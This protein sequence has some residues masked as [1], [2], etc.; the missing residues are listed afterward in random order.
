MISKEEF[1]RKVKAEVFP[2]LLATEQERKK[3][4]WIGIP[5]IVVALFLL[6]YVFIKRPSTEIGFQFVAIIFVG[7]L[8][9]SQRIWCRFLR[10]QKQNFL[11][12][13]LKF[14]GNLE[15]KQTTIDESLLK[16]SCLFYG[17]SDIEY[18][19]CL[20]GTFDNTH[21]S[22]AET[23]LRF[24]SRRGYHTIFEGIC[25]DIPMK[26]PVSGYTLLYNTKIP[27]NIPVLQ[28]ITLKDATFSNYQI[29]S[30]NPVNTKMLLTPAFMEKL[31]NL[32]KCFNNEPID[33]SFFGNHAF[34]AIYT[35]QDLFESYSM[36]RKVTDTKT[37][38]KFYD[39]IRTIYDMIQILNI[40]NQSLTATADCTYDKTLYQKI[41]SS[42]EKAGVF[43]DIIMLV[44]CIL[45]SILSWYLFSSS[46][47]VLALVIVMII[48]SHIYIAKRRF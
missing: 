36:F 5:W 42:A 26:L 33:V 34:F 19:D 12:T 17:F 43:S 47:V 44:G 38:E 3:L 1:I 29:F 20:S 8:G 16:H 11:P 23:E 30:N 37:Y 6:V 31:K 15:D 2:K 46:W 32:K 28:K 21:F 10:K 9:I 48:F 7:C 22:L 41:T 40:N 14:L 35:K 24:R 4:L 18:K 39:D 45:V 13:F 25:I 27:H